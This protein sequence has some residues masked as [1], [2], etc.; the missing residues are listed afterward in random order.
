MSTFF[1]FFVCAQE[2]QI[3]TAT[4]GA[5]WIPLWL[6]SKK[7]KDDSQGKSVSFSGRY[8]GCCKSFIHWVHT[9]QEHGRRSAA[10]NSHWWEL[11]ISIGFLNAYRLGQDD[12]RNWARRTETTSYCQKHCADNG[13]LGNQE[14]VIAARPWGPT[15]PGAGSGVL[16]D[17]LLLW[18]DFSPCCAHKHTVRCD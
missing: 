1:F 8:F 17:P 12:K 4:Q 14:Q 7:E 11:L 13:L 6:F 10:T 16:A 18:R 3:Q 5:G 2:A 9:L 15:T